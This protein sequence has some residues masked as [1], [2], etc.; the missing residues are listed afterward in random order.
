MPA[1]YLQPPAPLKAIFSIVDCSISSNNVCIYEIQPLSTS[2]IAPSANGVCEKDFK[3]KGLQL[4]QRLVGAKNLYVEYDNHIILAPHESAGQAVENTKIFLRARDCHDEVRVKESNTVYEIQEPHILYD[5]LEQKL[6]LSAYYPN[7]TAPFLI[8]KTIDF[9]SRDCKKKIKDFFI[10]TSAHA[11]ILKR[12]GT[13]RGKGNDFFYNVKSALDLYT[14]LQT[15]LKRSFTHWVV[16]EV[17]VNH[18]PA[19]QPKSVHRLIHAA[20]YD[21]HDSLVRTSLIHNDTYYSLADDYDSHSPIGHVNFLEKKHYDVSKQKQSPF[22]ATHPPLPPEQLQRLKSQLHN[23]MSDYPTLNLNRLF[24]HST[25][26][27]HFINELTWGQF[28]KKLTA[29]N[30]TIPSFLAAYSQTDLFPSEIKTHMPHK[31]AHEC[32]VLFF[33]GMEFEGRILLPGSDKIYKEL[34][35]LAASSPHQPITANACREIKLKAIIVVHGYLKLHEKSAHSYLAV[36]NKNSRVRKR[37]WRALIKNNAKYKDGSWY[38]LLT[39]QNLLDWFALAPE[40][41]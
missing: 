34:N 27:K 9:L 19:G 22:Y 26:R 31:F 17:C 2:V 33:T 28:C 21:E 13:T 15:A 23:I 11:F 35:A 32:K 12:P 36:L 38:F 20:L 37:I 7:L 30:T 4:Y 6:L 29:P 5:K 16:L 8:I 25:F 41:L 24:S 39:Q 1:P 10:R 40:A 3:Q 14:Q 18:T